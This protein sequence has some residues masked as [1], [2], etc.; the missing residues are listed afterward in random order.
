MI[1]WLYIFLIFLSLALIT[2]YYILNRYQNNQVKLAKNTISIKNDIVLPKVENKFN[3]NIMQTYKDRD[4]V[5]KDVIDN[6]IDKNKSWDYNFY[7]DEEAKRFLYFNFGSAFE[8]KFNSFKSGAHKA[9]L[10]R[11]CWLYINGGV[12][13]DIDIEL[14]YPLDD[15]I[16][17]NITKLELP[18]TDRVIFKRLL[19]AFMIAPSGDKMVG[20]CI[21]NIMKIDPEQLDKNYFLILYTM[22]ETLGDNYKYT[23]KEYNDNDIKT[24]LLGTRYI[25]YKNKKIA[26]SKYDNYNGQNKSFN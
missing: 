3:K 25:Y 7:D 6:I 9:D 23:F 26:K 21:K 15:I 19:N 13:I 24:I 2:S 1:T 16:D 8:E 4:S 5:P 17:F 11:L 22:K 12:Y 10:F 18:L 20:E 14:Y